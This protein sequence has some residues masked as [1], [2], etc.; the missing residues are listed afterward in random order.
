M[1]GALALLL[2]LTAGGC[3]YYN[4]LYNARGLVRRAE[5]ATRDGRDSA[6]ASAIPDLHC[7]RKNVP[8]LA[9]M[10]GE[11]ARGICDD[12]APE[13]TLGPGSSR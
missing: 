4:G 8:L 12:G 1:R 7:P 13:A 6:A 10:A 9:L 2:L 3:A 5:S 11:I